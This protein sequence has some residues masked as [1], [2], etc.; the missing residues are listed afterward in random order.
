MRTENLNL[1]KIHKD[2]NPLRNKALKLTASKYQT[3]MIQ[4][5]VRTETTFLR[6]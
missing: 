6:K 5:H 1:R 3:G 4:N 2:E